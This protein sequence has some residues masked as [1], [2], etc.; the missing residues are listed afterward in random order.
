MTRWNLVISD[1]TDR[2]VRSY[3]ARTGGKKGDLSRFVDRAV[4]QAIFWE[5]LESV[6]ERNKGLSPDEAQT[7]VDEAVAQVRAGHS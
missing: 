7:L 4:R 2:S 3:L 1:D 5:T 6:W